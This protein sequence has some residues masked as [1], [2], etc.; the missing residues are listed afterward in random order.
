MQTYAERYKYSNAGT[1]EFMALA[2]EVSG[3]D[4]RSFFDAWLFAESLPELQK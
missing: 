3:R 1:K 2:E 4:L